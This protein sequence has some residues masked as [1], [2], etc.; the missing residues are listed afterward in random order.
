MEHA[1]IFALI[2][3][4]FLENFVHCKERKDLYSRIMAHDLD[5]YRR[6]IKK[7]QKAHKT[8]HEQ[9]LERWRNGGGDA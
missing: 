7:P 8:A 2:F 6:D 4:I 5:D 3:F 9:V 1:I